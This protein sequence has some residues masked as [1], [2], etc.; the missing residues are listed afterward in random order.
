VSLVHASTLI[1][2]M[3]QYV[4]VYPFPIFRLA[5]DAGWHVRFWHD[6]G[7][8]LGVVVLGRPVVCII[9]ADISTEMQRYVLAH[10]MGHLMAA[11]DQVV[12]LCWDG[13]IGHEIGSWMHQ[14][15]E[16]EADMAAALLLLPGRAINA[17]AADVD[18]LAALCEVPL[19]LAEMRLAI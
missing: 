1:H 5:Q 16:K 7:H 11:H 15:Q 4:G 3:A 13:V 14:R 18:E 17:C 10:E 8:A 2:A 12:N 9:S 19:W 6:M